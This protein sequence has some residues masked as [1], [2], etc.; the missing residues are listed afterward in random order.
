MI[1]TFLLT[2]ITSFSPFVLLLREDLHIK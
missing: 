2:K 1:L